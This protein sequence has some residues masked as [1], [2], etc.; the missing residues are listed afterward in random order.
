MSEAV[1]WLRET[2]LAAISRSV[3]SGKDTAEALVER[4]RETFTLEAVALLEKSD[5]RWR[6][7]AAA[8]AEPA[9]APDVADTVLTVDERR[10]LALTGR[11]LPASDRRVLDAFASQVGILLEQ[12][13]LRV[14]LG[15]GLLGGFTTFSAYSLEVARMVESHAYGQAVIYATASVALAVTVLFGG[16]I[17]ARWVFA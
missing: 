12:E 9:W 15:V 17:L 13:R 11:A 4:L 7:L 5:G 1:R 8:G 10:V 6:T 3:L 2:S 16:I 14:L